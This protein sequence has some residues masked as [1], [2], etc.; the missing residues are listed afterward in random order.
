MGSNNTYQKL[1][2]IQIHLL[3]KTLRLSLV[4][5]LYLN[6]CLWYLIFSFVLG[7]DRLFITILPLWYKKLHIFLIISIYHCPPP[8]SLL[9]YSLG[10]SFQQM[11]SKWSI[12]FPT[13]F[14]F[15]SFWLLAIASWEAIQWSQYWAFCPLIC[16]GFIF[17]Y[18][19]L[20]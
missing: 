5:K 9:F 7:L 16:F 8:S 2:S 3:W 18:F 17:W 14:D 6:L 11:A 4:S 15:V 10:G 19:C 20:L 13:A 12:F 1:L